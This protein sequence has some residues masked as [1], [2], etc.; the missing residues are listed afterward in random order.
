M[1]NNR[2]FVVCL[3]LTILL[4]FSQCDSS[5]E[6]TAPEN[7]DGSITVQIESWSFL[8][9]KPVYIKLY[10]DDDNVY[11][12]YVIPLKEISV[13]LDQN[14]EGSFVLAD[15]ATG[16]EKYQ[17]TG[18]IDVAGAVYDWP[19]AGDYIFKKTTQKVDGDISVTVDGDDYYVYETIPGREF[20]QQDIGNHFVRIWQADYWQGSTS[21]GWMGDADNIL[22]RFDGSGGAIG[23]VSRIYSSAPFEPVR[24]DDVDSRLVNV[25]AEINHSGAGTYFFCIYGWVMNGL[26]W[27][28]SDVRHE[29]YVVETWNRNETDPY[30]ETVM[31]DSIEYKMYRYEFPDQ[32]GYRFKA[33]RQTDQRLSGPINMKPFFE[34]W[35]QNGMENYYL[36]EMTWAIELLT[37]NHEGTFYLWNIDIPVY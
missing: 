4:I 24:V 20:I 9:S 28:N 23:R 36:D 18:V 19:D 3:L 35:R 37:G 5:K 11:D 7:T 13:N 2:F 15:T 8:G 22:F 21:L 33:I 29:F 27:S 17:V 10:R 25:N 1:K 6:P 12:P 32:S 26:G 31:I 16:G 34:Y 14:G 30:I